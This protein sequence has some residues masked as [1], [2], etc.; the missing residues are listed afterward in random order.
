[1]SFRVRVLITVFLACAICT[2]GACIVA[3]IRTA[4]NGYAALHEKS[5]AILSRLEATRTYVATQDMLG[6]MI[7]KMVAQYPN[8]ELAKEDKLRVLKVVPIFASM[9]VGQADS[10]KEHYNFRVVAVDPRNKDHSPNEKDLTFLQR[11][12]QERELTELMDVDTQAKTFTLMRPV[13]LKEKD[14]CLNCH[15]DPKNSPWHNGKDVLGFQME[16][17]KDGKLHGMFQII[18]DLKPLQD[19]VAA[20]RLNIALWGLG[21]LLVCF[22][23]AFLFV[24]QPLRRFMATVSG[25]VGDL[26]NSSASV[27]RAG[28]QLTMSSS[29]LAQGASEQAASLEETAA[30]LEQVCTTVEHNTSHA[31]QADELSA[32][33][34]QAS[35]TGT[36]CMVRMKEAMDTIKRS[37]DETAEIIKN[38]D[39]IAFQTNLLALNAAVEAARAGEAGSG[40]AVV[41][42][43]V[44][45]L[46]Q[47]SAQAARDTALKIKRSAEHAVNGVRV[48][49]EVEHSLQTI[50]TN[51]GKAAELV[52]QIARGSK[53]QSTALGEIRIAVNELDKVTQQNAALSEESAAS[54]EDLLSEVKTLDKVIDSLSV[55][56]GSARRMREEKK[57][58]N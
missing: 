14:G 24:D 39:E 17:W 54:S 29:S 19:G 35:E 38:I 32:G 43:E 2:I 1:M 58:G 46:A 57:K 30:A 56:V 9:Q 5:S 55:L 40:F 52:A 22:V 11:F 34:R 28:Q 15:G 44:R 41:A 47:R 12:E 8:G 18:S 23:I 53:E 45:S 4:E 42:E 10:E 20:T 51:A 7:E 25:A 36:A 26:G 31:Q 27:L 48:S 13:I 33:V 50:R 37:A 3:G 6:S 49:H 21:I 16:N